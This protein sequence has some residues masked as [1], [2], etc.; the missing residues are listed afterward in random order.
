MTSTKQAPNPAQI[1][2]NLHEL[3]VDGTI[4]WHAEAVLHPD[5]DPT[6]VYSEFGG[7]TITLSCLGSDVVMVLQMAGE[8]FVFRGQSPADCG[9]I[10]RL[11]DAASSR[12]QRPSA[13]ELMKTVARAIADLK[14]RETA[15]EKPVDETSDADAG[16]SNAPDLPDAEHGLPEPWGYG[17]ARIA[18]LE[19]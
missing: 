10:K 8:N 11:Y 7:L 3:T 2:A 13:P 19:A 12:A 4:H 18:E 17:L 15:V 6:R 14:A 5:K 9:S 1:L 16:V